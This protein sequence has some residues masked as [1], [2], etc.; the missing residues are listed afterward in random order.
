MAEELNFPRIT[1]DPLPPS[2]RSLDEIDA[3]IQQDYEAFFDREAYEKQKRELS[4][5]VPF[6]L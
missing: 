2:I 4:V 3:W 6:K 5:N 1:G